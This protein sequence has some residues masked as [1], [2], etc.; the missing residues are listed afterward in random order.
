MLS[1]ALKCVEN[2]SYWDQ[3]L[4]FC[5]NERKNKRNQ[6]NHSLFTV[7]ELWSIRFVWAHRAVA[8]SYI[9]SPLPP[10]IF[11]LPVIYFPY[12]SCK[13]VHLYTTAMLLRN[14]SVK[15]LSYY[16]SHFVKT[17]FFVTN[18]ISHFISI[19][20]KRI[21]TKA[22]LFNLFILLLITCSTV[23]FQVG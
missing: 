16:D 14:S 9:A 5:N 20:I 10:Y 7:A 18:I 1:N 3:M 13:N 11:L 8:A 23:H 6:I 21:K 2:Q 22:C 17:R 19:L 15:P 12:R 4:L